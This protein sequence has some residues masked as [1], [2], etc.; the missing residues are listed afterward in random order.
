MS[1]ELEEL[2]PEEQVDEEPEKLTLEEQF[3]KELNKLS[4]LIDQVAK[5]D[6]AKSQRQALQSAAQLCRLRERSIDRKGPEIQPESRETV[7]A[8]QAQKLEAIRNLTRQA[9]NIPRRCPECGANLDDYDID[10]ILKL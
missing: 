4:G 8:T 1:E 6:S 10:D 7:S 3:A 5:D 2:A 9:N